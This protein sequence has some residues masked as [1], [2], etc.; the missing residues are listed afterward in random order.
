MSLTLIVDSSTSQP[1]G[2]HHAP[3]LASWDGCVSAKDVDFYWGAP[4]TNAGIIVPYRAWSP[5][6]GGWRLLL[7][8]LNREYPQRI[9]MGSS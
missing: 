6:H 2:G 8:D 9:V 5:S 1:F 7:P 4:A 3:V